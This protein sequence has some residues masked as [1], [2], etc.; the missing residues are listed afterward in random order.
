MYDL[1]CKICGAHFQAVGANA[2]YCEKCR[3]AIKKAQCAEWYRTHA[4][5]PESR[6]YICK[7]CGRTVLV[8]GTASNRSI[9]NGCCK[10]MGWKG[11]EYLE[12][13]KDLREEY[14]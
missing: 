5:R 11:R 1:S 7:R 3:K 9:C 4:K 12:I 6:R 10:Q 13:R 8:H 2:K 14:V